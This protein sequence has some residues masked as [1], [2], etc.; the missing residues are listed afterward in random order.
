MG[1]PKRPSALAAVALI[2]VAASVAL[3]ILA[4]YHV[5]PAAV[6]GGGAVGA[7]AT[8]RV[9]SPAYGNGSAIPA[10]Y[11]CDGADISPPLAWSG[12]PQGAKSLLVEMVDPDAPGGEFIHWV[13]YNISPN[14]TGLPQG[15]PPAAA[16]AYGLQAVNDFGEVGYGGPCPPPGRPHR[17]IVLVLA[18]N[19]TLE[20]P[21]GAPA[22]QVLRAAGPY[23]VG[24]GSLVGLYGR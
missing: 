4:L 12:V 3:A 15:V 20:V 5:R 21:P 24:L 23:V 17:Y 8:I 1:L 22:R 9:Y 7:A 16:T 11:T 18:L 2:A 14:S 13:I 19:A 6:E 10:Q